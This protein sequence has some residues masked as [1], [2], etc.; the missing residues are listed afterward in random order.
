MTVQDFFLQIILFLIGTAV[1]FYTATHPNDPRLRKWGWFAGGLAILAAVLWAGYELGHRSPVSA[2]GA[3]TPTGAIVP[4]TGLYDDFNNPVYNG[5]VNTTLWEN[6]Q[7]QHCDIQQ[8]DGAAVFSLNAL[9]ADSTTCYL[10][11]RQ[12]VPFTEV[13]TVKASLL[14]KNNAQGDYS[15]GVIEYKTTGFAPNTVW[16]AQCGIIQTPK[17]HKVELFFWLNNS[18]PT[19]QAE[20]YETMSASTDQWY[21]MRLELDPYGAGMWCFANDKEVGKVVP[22]NMDFL[23]S[24]IFSRHILSY[25]SANSNATYEAD[26]VYLGP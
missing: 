3:P 9:W 15:I 16:L 22:S 12:K 13:G 17:D 7:V 23:R 5:S 1:S 8:Q 25:W 24:Q 4:S 20:T 14:G 6:F 18:Y 26:D 21:K 11:M 19:G 2:P 10:N